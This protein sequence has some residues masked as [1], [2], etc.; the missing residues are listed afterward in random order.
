MDVTL[1][2]YIINKINH[3]HERD[4]RIYSD[5]KSS[6]EG[7]LNKGNSFSAHE[8]NT[9]SLTIE[10][11]EFLNGLS[12]GFMNNVFDKNLS[13]TYVLRNRQE[14]YSRNTKTVMELKPYHIWHL[15]FGARFLKL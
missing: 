13:N 7:I 9:Q 6:F 10:N 15:K 11:Y 12:S 8:R 2:K 5:Y 1:K 4:S 3:F 14:L